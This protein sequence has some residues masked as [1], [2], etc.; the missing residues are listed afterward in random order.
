MTWS[1]PYGSYYIFH[2]FLLLSFVPYVFFFLLLFCLF[3]L[4]PSTTQCIDN[5]RACM[6]SCE[7]L[8]NLK[9]AFIIIFNGT[10]W[11]CFTISLWVN[12]NENEWGEMTEKEWK[13]RNTQQLR[14]VASSGNIFE[15]T[16]IDVFSL[17][18]FLW[19]QDHVLSEIEFHKWKT[20]EEKKPF[21]YSM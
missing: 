10:I 2:V 13:E 16:H 6:C 5:L 19:K 1:T 14:I 7:K 17:M 20:E 8:I 3:Y 18:F 21:S 4:W 15:Y 12:F 9:W 11:S